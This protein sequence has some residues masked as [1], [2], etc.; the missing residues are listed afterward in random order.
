MITAFEDSLI[1]L[2]VHKGFTQ[3]K[4]QFFREGCNKLVQ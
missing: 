4:T 1:K 2:L 3:I